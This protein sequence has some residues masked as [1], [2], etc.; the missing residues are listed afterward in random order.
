MPRT[1]WSRTV[2]RFA[3]ARG[4][5]MTTDGGGMASRFAM[6][7]VVF[8]IASLLSCSHNGPAQATGGSAT[9]NAGGGNMAKTAPAGKEPVLVVAPNGETV[10]MEL[11][12][13]DESRARGFMERSEI[14]RGTG[15]YFLF[16]A[17]GRHQFWMFNTRV[18]LDIAWLDASH[19]VI[20]LVER[21][22]VCLM[23]PCETYAPPSVASSVIELGAGEARRLG[24]V[25][26]AQVLVRNLPAGR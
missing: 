5:E 24:I 1:S 12:A 8:A 18:P 21:A 10:V 23:Q 3:P 4:T 16:D 7:A 14:P 25:P 11:A 19:T 26:G 20:Y 2:A 13:D 9:G 22:P 6:V 15:M 17:P